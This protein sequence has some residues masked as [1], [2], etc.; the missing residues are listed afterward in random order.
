M[1]RRADFEVVA[2][3]HKKFA[4]KYLGDDDVDKEL[5]EVIILKPRT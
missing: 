2:D 3:E 4:R 5:P 1:A